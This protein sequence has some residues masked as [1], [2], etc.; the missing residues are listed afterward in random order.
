MARMH[1]GKK[2]KAGSKRPSVKSFSW[3]R[4]KPREVELLIVKLAKEEKTPS[5][6]GMTLR[7]TYGIPDVEAIT[8]KRISA[9]L[10][11][12]KL[13]QEIPEDLMALIKKS[14]MIRKH[15]ETNKKDMPAKRGLELT[16]S[17]IRRLIKY[18]KRVKKLPEE[19]KYDPDRIRL[20][21]K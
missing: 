20:M 17:K 8:H 14:I 21:I 13:L 1:S 12:K 19:W 11:E 4:Y 9:V 3:V 5:M 2:G 15:L 10:A 6:I 16:E 7:D 18:F